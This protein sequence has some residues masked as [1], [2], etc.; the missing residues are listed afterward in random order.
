MSRTRHGRNRRTGRTKIV[1][2]LHNAY[3]IGGTVRTTLNLAAALA[4]HHDVEIVSM[5]RHRD[6]PRFTVDPRITVVPL[7][8]ERD[9]SADLTDPDYARPATDFPASE[10]RYE[11]YT[12]LTDLRAA[13][14]LTD[15]DADV[16]IGTRPGINVYVAL[17]APR[18]ALR[19]AQ[20][21]LRHDQHSK[22]LRG[23]LARHYRR[24]DAVVTTTEADAEVYRRRMTL[25]G[26]RVAAVPNIVP[27][28]EGITRDETTKVVAAAGRLVTG[29]RFDLLIEAFS[30]VASKEPDWR[31]RI[32]GGGAQRDHLQDLVTGLGLSEH[33]RLMGPRTPIEAEFAKSAMVVSASDAES[34][35]MTLVE[36]MRCGVPVIS[37]DCPLGPAEIITEGVDGRLVPVGDSRAL[38]EAML[39]LITDEPLRRA[40]GAAALAGSHRYDAEPIVARYEALFTELRSTRPRRSWARTRARTAGW[41]RRRIRRLRRVL[42][43]R[44]QPQLNSDGTRTAGP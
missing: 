43:G 2:L 38:A 35:G 27:A 12:R 44:P 33:V 9:G 21:H 3:A 28:P 32:Y 5:R 16:I 17:F 29:K 1:F 15:C 10:K 41:A 6:E 22:R 40:M 4:D 7:V 31:L 18:R 13:A 11:Q 26:V 42:P 37:T 20:E 23:V 8:D 25:P 30:A 19:I 39:D 14:Y 36:A 24:L 34:F